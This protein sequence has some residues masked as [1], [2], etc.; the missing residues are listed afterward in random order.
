MRRSVMD[1][2]ATEKHIKNMTGNSENGNTDDK[3]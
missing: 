3:R 1:K 2:K